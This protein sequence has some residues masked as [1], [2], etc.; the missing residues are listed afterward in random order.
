MNVTPFIA[1]LIGTTFLLILG[2]GVV[3][4]VNLSKTKGSKETPLITI[5]TA[6]GFAVF[7][8]AYVT[9][10]FSG[11]HLNPAVTIGLV[12]AGKFSVDLMIGYIIAQ[13]LGAMLGSH[14]IY[15]NICKP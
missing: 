4:N 15:V 12:V 8:A 9:G 2:Q 14:R 13:L 7:V 10:E 5:T 3:A 6:W 11:A 1:E